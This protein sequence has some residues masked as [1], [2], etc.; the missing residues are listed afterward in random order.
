MST[1]ICSGR[2]G[3]HPRCPNTAGISGR[4]RSITSARPHR[5]LIA[6]SRATARRPS[7]KRS[8]RSGSTKAPTST[9]WRPT[10]C[11]ESCIRRTVAECARRSYLRCHQSELPPPPAVLRPQALRLRALHLRKT[12]PA[13]Q[14]LNSCTS[15]S[16]SRWRLLDQLSASFYRLVECTHRSRPWLIS[17]F[18]R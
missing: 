10:A 16:R 17:N 18:S 1:L 14:D 8:Y 13:A 6:R 11:T 4:R 12:A 15:R 5:R 3:H 2:C 7:C 9:F